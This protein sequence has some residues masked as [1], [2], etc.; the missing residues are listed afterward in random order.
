[1]WMNTLAAPQ[2]KLHFAL[3]DLFSSAHL[4]AL[5]AFTLALQTACDP[6]T[7]P[8]SDAMILEG[9]NEL[10]SSL[11]SGLDLPPVEFMMEG[12]LPAFQSETERALTKEDRFDTRGGFQQIYGETAPPAQ[13]LR[14]LG[15][16]EATEGVLIAW[17]WD[18]SEYLFELIIATSSA[19]KVWVITANQRESARLERD[20]LRAGVSKANLGFFEFSH[21]GIWTRDFG[22]WTAVDADGNPAF[23]DVIYYP[24]RRRDDAVPT[25]MGRYFNAPTYRAPVEIEG[26]NF[27]S[28][29]AGRCFFS[30]K[31]LEV[32]VGSD[33]QDLTDLFYDYLGCEYSV[34]LEPLY[35]EETGHIDMFSKLVGP[36][37]MLVGEYSERDDSMNSY[38]LERNVQKIRRFAEQT[39]WPLEIIRI[40]MPAPR[41]SGAYPS[42]TNSLI[43]ND[44]VIIPIYPSQPQY[45]R[46]AIAAYQ[47]A[48]SRAYRFITLNA[49]DI[50]EMGGAIHCTTMGFVT[51]PALVEP[52]KSTRGP[53][54]T[55]ELDP[56]Q[57]EGEWTST[58][59][60][61]IP[62]GGQLVD[63]LVI[64]EA[65]TGANQVQVR[66]Q[67]THSYPADLQIILVKGDTQ[68]NL[69]D[70]AQQTAGQFT[71][72]VTLRLP[73]RF[74]VQGEWQLL[75]FD[76][77][78]QDD[79]VLHRWSLRFSAE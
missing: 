43:V 38:L 42:Y 56:V 68:V 50:I 2:K 55:V 49:D 41:R 67:I 45:E 46:A 64:P 16:F 54:P 58:P 13:R 20:L 3:A 25:L 28:D 73:D 24:N 66:Y 11:A 63:T 17:D 21:E 31:V 40:P 12:R 34:I 18:E 7:D 52:A 48:F 22:P 30:S 1:M 78:A 60:K 75:I 76:R 51:S 72:E 32:N 23:I 36:N 57:R 61:R 10:G 59:E 69:F 4:S 79:G 29:G 44:T 15:E 19:S 9:T 62:D 14:A 71:K 27:M 6:S 26:G 65:L 39:D 37:T 70:R 33:A 53:K 74:Q 47:R 77:E 8:L 5:F 35:G